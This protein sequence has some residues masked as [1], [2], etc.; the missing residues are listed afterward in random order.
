MMEKE[1][2]QEVIAMLQERSPN[3]EAFMGFYGNHI[4]ANR[5]GLERYAL[6]LLRASIGA[7]ENP[8]HPI[9]T[10]WISYDTDYLFHYIEV[11][12]GPSEED[13]YAHG[14]SLKDT[15]SKISYVL[16]GFIG[17]TVLGIGCITIINWLR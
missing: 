3:E 9:D 1:K 13:R 16:I 4:R 12:K 6:E 10:D 2:I 17:L 8:T 15:I 14:N 7:D 11:N 5:L